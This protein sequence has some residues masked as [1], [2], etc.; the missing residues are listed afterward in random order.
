METDNKNIIESSLAPPNVY[1]KRSAWAAF[2][3]TFLCPGLGHLY[4]GE[5]KRGLFFFLSILI[6]YSSLL[7]LLKFTS[8]ILFLV[9]LVLIITPYVV[10][11]IV[12]AIKIALE[13]KQY[14]LKKYNRWFVY[15]G[16]L[17]FNIYA[18][19]PITNLLYPL[20]YKTPSGSMEKTVL[21]GDLLMANDLA[22]KVE[23]PYTSNILFTISKPQRGDV[24]NFDFPGFRDE[25]IPSTKV[26]YLKRIMGIPGDTVEIVNKVVFINR[27]AISNPEGVQFL[28]K[29][30]G[31]ES[32]KDIFPKGSGWNKDNYGPLYV[33]K[34][35]DKI[36]LRKENYYW[37]DTFIKREGHTTELWAN[38][39]VVIDDW[40]TS[41]YTVKNNYYFTLGDNRDNS[42]DS[43]YW[44]FV[45]EENI[46]G[47]I[48]TVYWSWDS[49]IPFKDSGRLLRSIRW[50]R[51]GT[52][53][54]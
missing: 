4:C 51:I 41:S 15:T 22:Y 33:P 9:L 42:L 45:P 17:I 50:D 52:I 12:D 14:I 26:Q 31:S 27:K 25:I 54:K 16:I 24:I 19:N 49:S 37:W 39:N 7:I 46:K 23:N 36:A 20:A 28:S 53:I 6:S 21:V 13:K 11:I 44:G 48:T 47:K 35:G 32:N 18:V 34:K 38:G 1:K 8:N 5:P 40:V 43:R 2:T 10:Y 29:Y 30:Y 3:F